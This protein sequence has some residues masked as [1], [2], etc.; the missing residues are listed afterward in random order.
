MRSPFLTCLS[1]GFAALLAALST[2]SLASNQVTHTFKPSK[3]STL[4]PSRVVSTRQS[5]NRSVV[6]AAASEVTDRAFSMIGTPYRWGGTT[7]KK[8]FDCSGLVN[9]VF[10]DVDDVDLPRTARAI[11]NMDNNKVSRGKLQPA[12]LVF[13]RIRSRSVDHVGIYVGNDRFVHAPRRGKKVRVSD[14]NS[15]Y[16]KRHYL[17]GKRILPT[18]LAQVESTRKR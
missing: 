17:A 13:F 5:A 15:S 12:D 11:Y 1:V 10:Q 18:T 7:P 2:P 8:G 14:L 16:W 6:A 3:N 9:Y 4:S